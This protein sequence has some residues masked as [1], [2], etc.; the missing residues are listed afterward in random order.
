MADEIT[1]VGENNPAIMKAGENN[2]EITTE[3][4]E[5]IITPA[6]PE[7]IP[8]KE[9]KRFAKTI[10]FA[11]AEFIALEKICAARI[12]S[13]IST[14]WN[15]FLRQLIDYAINDRSKVYKFARPENSEVTLKNTFE[16]MDL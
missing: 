6:P 10:N 1:E 3:V 14:D 12:E 7:E 4:P 13:G 16:I 9:P 8:S 5:T 11:P 2:P 15:H